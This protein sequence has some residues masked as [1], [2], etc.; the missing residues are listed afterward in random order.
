MTTPNENLAE[1]IFEAVAETFENMAFME[2][3][4]V[5]SDDVEPSSD[6]TLLWSRIAVLQPVEGELTLLASEGLAGEITE[7]IFG[8]TD[9]DASPDDMAF[10]ALAELINTIAGRLMAELIP[11]DQAFELGLPETGKGWP[12]G[13]EEEIAYHFDLEGHKLM[14]IVQG[15][16][17]SLGMG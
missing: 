16:F 7:A 17:D 14:I 3:V 9:E 2:A 13:S 12:Q 4:P 10:D 8:E 15:E 5:S 6:S 1:K 11:Q